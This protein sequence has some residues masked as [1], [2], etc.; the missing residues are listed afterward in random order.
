MK[1][2]NVS[3]NDE[4]GDALSRYQIEH[5]LSSRDQALEAILLELSNSQML[6]DERKIKAKA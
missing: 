1:R 6:D 2:I 5:K 4:A 3:V